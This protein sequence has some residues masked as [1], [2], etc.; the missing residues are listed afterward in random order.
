MGEG[1]DR[2]RVMILKSANFTFGVF[3]RHDL[4]R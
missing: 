1:T 3:G 2:L 4:G